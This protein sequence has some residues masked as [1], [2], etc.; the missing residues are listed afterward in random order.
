M[1]SHQEDLR[2][3]IRQ[4]IAGQPQPTVT[5]LSSLLAVQDALGWLPAE[6]IEEVATRTGATI[7]DVWAVASFYTNF[8]FSPPGPH[9]VEVCWG[10]T[11]H[12]LGAQAILQAV[13][14]AVGLPGEGDTPDGRYSLKLNTC[15]GACAQAPALALGHRIYGRMTPET[16]RRLVEGVNQGEAS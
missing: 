4:A 7:N 6:A 10:P 13:Q 15:L 8:R 11:C 3:R 9:T 2:Q 12:L 1:S 16:A 14:E 5:I